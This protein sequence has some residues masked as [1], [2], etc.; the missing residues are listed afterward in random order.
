MSS[1]KVDLRNLDF[2]NSGSWPLQVKL[3]FCV[4]VAAIIVSEPVRF[5]DN[6]NSWGSGTGMY[7]TMESFGI[8]YHHV[9]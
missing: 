1:K 8:T 2:N 9:S 7:F 5:F 6:S 3:G 4:L